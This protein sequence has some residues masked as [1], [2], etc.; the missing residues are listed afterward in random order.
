M[1]SLE[2]TAPAV[3]AAPVP[4]SGTVHTVDGVALAL[5]RWRARARPRAVVAL[6]HGLAEHAQRY[7]ALA[8]RL[9]AA[10]IELVAVDLRGHGRSPGERTWVR[11]FDDYLYDAQALLAVAARGDAP[12]I[13]MGHSMGGAIATLYALERGRASLPNAPRLA[14]LVLSSPALAPGRD[15][16][17]WMIAASRLTSRIW[18]RYPAMRIDPALLSRDPAVVAANRADPLVHH[19]SIPA[20]TGAE[21]LAAMTRIERGRETLTLPVLVYHGTRDKLTEPEGS[22]AF[23]SHVGSQD[24]TLTLYEGSYHETMN[25]LDRDRVIDALIEWIARHA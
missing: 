9:N 11:R 14:G 19:A 7:S 5:Y 18:P 2:S 23:A 12:V 24:V 22:R 20:R 8:A 6:V 16:P 15:V 3:T 13:L 1:A 21:L 10:D 17:G 4:E 25:D